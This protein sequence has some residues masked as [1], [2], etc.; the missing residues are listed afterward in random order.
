MLMSGAFSATYFP[1]EQRIGQVEISS[2]V[3]RE[4]RVGTGHP[5]THKIVIGS[6]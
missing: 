4:E 2:S 1:Q 6:R 5:S 3:I